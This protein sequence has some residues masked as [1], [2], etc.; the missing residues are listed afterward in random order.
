[1]RGE[2][3]EKMDRENQIKNT[4]VKNKRE[5]ETPRKIRIIEDSRNV[6]M[7]NNYTREDQLCWISENA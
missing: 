3:N 5:I 7:Y 4:R 1:M 6:V 2:T